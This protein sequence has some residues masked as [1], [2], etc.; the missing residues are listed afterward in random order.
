LNK[1]SS[2]DQRDSADIDR[3]FADFIGSFGGG[4][5]PKLAA[6]A[7]SRNI[8]SGHI[9]LDLANGPAPVDEDAAWPSLKKWK[10]ALKESRAVASG[11]DD[12][13]AA[14]DGSPLVLDKAGRL[15]L[16]RYWEYEKFLAAAI[17][18]R[19]DKNPPA[20][21]NSGDLHELAIETALA[22]RFVVISGG[23]GTGK[24]TAILKILERLIDAPGGKNLR[25]ALAAP[26][27]KAAARLEESLRGGVKGGALVDERLPKSASTLHRLLGW[28]SDSSSFRHNSK[29]PLPVDLVVVDESSMVPLTMMAK[30]FEAL[31]PQSRIILLGDQH[32]LAS[33]EPGYVLSD[34]AEAASQ[35]GSPLHGSLVA[36]QKNYR[37]GDKSHIFAL[38][39]AARE[40]DT[41]HMFEILGAGDTPDLSMAAT[42]SAGKLMEKLRPAILAGYSAYLKGSNPAE[43]LKKFQKFRVL[44][45]LRSGPYGIENLN[46]KIEEILRSEGLVEGGSR[47]YAGLPVLITRNDY[48]LRL[49]NGDIGIL[50]P[51]PEGNALMAW[52]VDEVGGL[53]KIAPARLP[54][55]EPAFAMTV[56][57]SQGS[58]YDR[59]LLIL[60][61]R[62]SP[63]VTRELIYTGLTR[64]RDKVEVWYQE[65]ALREAIE[66]KVPRNSGLKDRL[67]KGLK[68]L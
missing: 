45:A 18:G 6:A 33:V 1:N 7:L 46:R 19:C 15:Y 17:L 67:T 22:K 38:S 23:P 3:H 41:T 49:F 61:D 32:Q 39:N 40:G 9:C 34:I 35:P 14:S 57:K 47:Y 12:Y 62:E 10:A 48:E 43:A 20:R 64:A 8:R 58:E 60:P 16:R 26:T 36:F 51:D 54:E 30:L 2:I 37:F 50:F 42:P 13:P 56:H 44:C 29:N 65:A 24:T 59:I 5:L 28:R 27:G 63:V 68:S 31:P 52:F 53:R 4:D 25:I 11:D 66:R 21:S 55:Y